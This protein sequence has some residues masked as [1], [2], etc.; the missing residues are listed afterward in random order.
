ML[1]NLNLVALHLVALKLGAVTLVNPSWQLQK[2]DNW[3]GRRFVYIAYSA[4]RLCH[5][6]FGLIELL[7]I[8]NGIVGV[9]V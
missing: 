8:S 4:Q 9:V 3:F 5:I 2:T 6:F 1:G 7:H